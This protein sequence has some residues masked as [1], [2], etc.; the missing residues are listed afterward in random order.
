[1]VMSNSTKTNTHATNNRNNSKTHNNNDNNDNTTNNTNTH[2]SPPG[3]P[4]GALLLPILS[5]PRP[6]L[7]MPNTNTMK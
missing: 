7:L 2:T 6:I 5:I 1:M 3:P 4:A